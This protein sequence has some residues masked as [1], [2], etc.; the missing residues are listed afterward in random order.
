M[1]NVVGRF[2][3]LKAHKFEQNR[4]ERVEIKGVTLYKTLTTMLY[5][6]LLEFH[7]NYGVFG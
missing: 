3:N 2:L 4:I 7:I 1:V 5:L 6:G